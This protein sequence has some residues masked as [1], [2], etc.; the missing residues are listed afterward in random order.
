MA[1]RDRMT[2]EGVVRRVLRD[3]QVDVIREPVRVVARELMEAEVSELVGAELGERRP[4]DRATHRN[5]YRA[6]RWDTRAGEIE[7]QIPKLRQGSYFPAVL[8]PRRRGSIKAFVSK[9]RSLCAPAR[10]NG[11]PRPANRRAHLACYSIKVSHTFR[12]RR[13]VVTNQLQRATRMRV[14]APIELCLPTGKSLNPDT[15]PLPVEGLDHFGCYAVK[16]PAFKPV[17]VRLADQFGR[18]SEV[19]V[20]PRTL[21]NPIRKNRGDLLHPTD[22]LRCYVFR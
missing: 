4:D 18:R 8:E 13:V 3:E 21:C 6:R 10:K 22:H 5:G 1:G 20:R 15:A 16:S 7:L 9:P 11:E 19:V 14:V 17:K 12:R 2:I